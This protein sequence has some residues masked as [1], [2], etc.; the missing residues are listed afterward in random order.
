MRDVP[1][2]DHDPFEKGPDAAKA[3]KA[4]TE[5]LGYKVQPRRMTQAPDWRA[6]QRERIATGELKPLPAAWDLPE[7]VDHFAHLDPRDPAKIAYT[8]SPEH[9][10]IDRTTSLTPGRYISRFF[11][12]ISDEHRRKLIAAI[13][14]SG[15]VFFATT[16]E[17]IT[18]IYKTGPKSCMSGEYADN[19][20]L[21]PAWPS[22]A[23]AAGDL[24]L[25]YQI[26]ASGSI[27]SRALCW[28]EKKIFGRM[29]GDPARLQPALE[30]EG[31]RYIRNDNTVD[32][33]NKLE[34]IVGAKLKKIPTGRRDDEFVV[35]YFDD[36]KVAIDMGDHFVSAEA[37]EIGQVY[38]VSGGSNTGVSVLHKFCPKLDQSFPAR[39]FLF[40]H[41]ANQEWS[42]KAIEKFAFTCSGTGKLWSSEHKVRMATPGIY[43]SQEHFAEHGEHCTVTGKNH[44]KSEMVQKGELRVHQSV[45]EQFDDQGNQLTVKAYRDSKKLVTADDWADALNF[46]GFRDEVIRNAARSWRRDY[47]GSWTDFGTGDVTNNVNVE[48][49]QIRGMTADTVIIDDPIMPES[50]L[51]PEQQQRL[52]SWMSDLIDRSLY[53]SIVADPL[54]RITR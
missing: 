53:S 16:A 6:R 28:P 39:E 4:L 47:E 19:F 42:K 15:E 11:D 24:A 10:T 23:Y 45:A 44:P 22:E 41:G 1:L 2:P 5:Q 14:P 30:A 17:E 9:G 12:P 8:A 46:S 50:N 40:V 29:Y 32:G 38:I 3:A 35:P 31:Y 51:S 54:S 13:D 27:Q 26:N 18:R 52:V 33:N 48:P 7:I 25:A 37:G 43:W 49:N 36:I 20:A 21:L 34:S